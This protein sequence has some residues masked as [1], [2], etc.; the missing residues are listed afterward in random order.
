[1]EHTNLFL[2]ETEEDFLVDY[3]EGKMDQ[4]V[5]GVAYI[6]G[7][8]GELG[9]LH[10]NRDITTY[11]ITIH[12]TDK[13]GVT[14]AEDYT[15]ET[16]AVLEGNEVKMNIVAEEVEG[17]KPR[18]AIEKATFS[19]NSSHTIIYLVPT[20]YTVTVNHVYS[21]QSIASATT[22]EVDDVYEEDVVRVKVEPLII[23]GYT[24]EPVYI[25]VSGDMTY[26]LEYEEVGGYEAIDL[27]LPSGTLWCSCNVGA[28]SPEECGGYFAWGEIEPNK[29]TAYTEE[30]YRFY[31]GSGNE[32]S[33]YN[34]KDELEELELVDDAAHVIMGGD[35]H[36]PTNLQM[37]ELLE[38]TISSW[39]SDYN[40]TGVA[41]L[42]LT[43]TANTN[44][45]FLPAAGEY[46]DEGPGGIGEYSELWCQD[47]TGVFGAYM[48]EFDNSLCDVG[49][50]VRY[51]GLTIRGVIGEGPE[52]TPPQEPEIPSL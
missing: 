15:I 32:Y 26:N 45:I 35:W 30:N 11:E 48:L 34:S 14:V 21:G 40:G 28:S 20:A 47:L 33:K 17:Y 22:I 31:N 13:S 18:Y 3:P 50:I 19:G 38:N 46:M 49:D 5:P 8:A 25:S 9:T 52:P 42:I 27:G 6:G 44:S 24:A 16:P 36:I 41:G 23:P 43:S 12:S 1:M 51:I 37:N 10:V 4:P 29:A 39:T 7:E 2:Y